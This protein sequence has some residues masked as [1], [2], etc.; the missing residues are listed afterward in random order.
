[1]HVRRHTPAQPDNHIYTHTHTHAHAHARAHAHAHAH[2]HIH[3]HTHAHPHPDDGTTRSSAHIDVF[4]G[5]CSRV[6]PSLCPPHLVLCQSPKALPSVGHA[7]P[8]WRSF[9]RGTGTA[10]V[11]LR[12]GRQSRGWRPGRREV[13]AET[14]HE[15]SCCGV[16][17]HKSRCSRR[18]CAR[19]VRDSPSLFFAPLEQLA[20]SLSHHAKPWILAEEWPVRCCIASFCVR[21]HAWCL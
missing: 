9:A 21:Y 5:A 17:E 12:K 19:E 3:T 10:A 4:V 15:Y 1:M 6:D 11:I 16:S 7:Q 8:H 18:H 20:P 2:T 14:Q 13:Q